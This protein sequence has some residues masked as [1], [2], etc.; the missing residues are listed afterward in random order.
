MNAQPAAD[1]DE[2]YRRA[3]LAGVATRQMHRNELARRIRC[4]RS[5]DAK[6]DANRSYRK[7]AQECRKSGQYNRMFGIGR[8]PKV[9][10]SAT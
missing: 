10:G 8:G 3:V 5:V 1:A 7:A 2:V 4:M 6:N 9:T